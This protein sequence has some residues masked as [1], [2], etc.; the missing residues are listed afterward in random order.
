MKETAVELWEIERIKQLKARYCRLLDAKEWSAWAGVFTEDCE[1]Y[2]RPDSDEI[3]TGRDAWVEFVAA[4]IGSGPSLHYAFMPEVR[5]LDETRATG[6][7]AMFG[8]VELGTSADGVTVRNFGHYDERYRK[9][10]DGHWRICWQRLTLSQS[11][12]VP[13]KS[14]HLVV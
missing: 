13:A 5:L 3:I 4:S 1:M 11:T 8:A 9:E 6:V 7:W 2:A 14:T 12:V 10:A